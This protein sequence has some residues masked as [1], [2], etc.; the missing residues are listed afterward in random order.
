VLQEARD[1]DDNQLLVK[2]LIQNHTVILASIYGPNGTDPIFFSNLS[3]N[4]HSLGDFPI[5]VGGDW[6]TTYSGLPLAANPDIINM[7]NLPNHPNCKSLSALCRNKKLIDPFRLLWPDRLDYSYTPRDI[8]RLN[9]S[10]LDFFLISRDISVSVS[11]CDIAPCVQSKLFDHKAVTLS[12]TGKKPVVTI[13]TISP[14]ILSDPDLEIVIIVSLVEIYTRYRSD[15]NEIQTQEILGILGRCRGLLRDA[16]PDPTFAGGGAADVNADTDIR[17]RNIAAI[18]QNLTE[19]NIPAMQAL[20][21][22]I[23]DDEFLEIL[24]NNLRNDIISYQ[25]HVLNLQKTSK[26]KLLD[27]LSNAKKNLPQNLDFITDLESKLLIIEENELSFITDK[28]AAFENINTE[29]ITPFFL[30]VIKGNKDLSSQNSIKNQNGVPF[31][32]DQERKEYIREHFAKI[33][34]KDP[35]EPEDL[36]GCIENFLGP[37]ILNN[38]VVQNSKLSDAEKTALELPLTMEELNVS[39]AGANIS[40][41]PGIDGFNTRFVRKF[42]KYFSTPLLK[43]ANC[44]FIR[45]HLTRSFRTAVLKLIPK[46]G[47]CSDINKWRPI[48]LLSCLYKIISRAINNRLKLVVNRFTTRAQKGFTSHRY[49]QE[50]LINVIETINYC[51][52]NGVSGAMVSIDQ[53]KAFDTI[54]HKYCKEV[55]K[56]FGFGEQFINMMETIGTG[57]SAIILFEDGSYSREITLGRSRPQGDGPSPIQYNMGEGILLLKIEL[58]PEV[59]SVYQHYL[60]PNFTMK[61]NPLANLKKLKTI[62]KPI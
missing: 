28:N 13:P 20:P 27:K 33:Y 47:D 53:S 46:K 24:I 35:N 26:K 3:N 44:C 50:V 18:L 57:R 30:K 8:T 9:R 39:V 51:K 25:S 12:F 52:K 37:E 41:A 5:V 31:S 19:F 36:S 32:C 54:S 38:P 11:E 34:A 45:G 29:R 2:C 59:S 6:N 7:A 56:F 21:L 22:S 43:Y 58:D 17:T 23:P 4:I 16:G 42:W 62:T 1:E 61:F 14:K 40:S 10:R 15:L 48:S 55:Y 49:I 60:A